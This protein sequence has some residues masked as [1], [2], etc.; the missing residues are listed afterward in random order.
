VGVLLISIKISIK[1]REDMAIVLSIWS[2]FRRQLKPALAVN[3]SANAGANLGGPI[4]VVIRAQ[5]GC[6]F[7]WQL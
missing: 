6:Q 7:Q 2:Q 1:A 5:F 3:S 4:P